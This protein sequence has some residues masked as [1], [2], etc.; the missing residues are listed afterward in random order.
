MKGDKSTSS[1]VPAHYHLLVILGALAEVIATELLLEYQ[2]HKQNLFA[3]LVVGRKN[4]FSIGLVFIVGWF[5]FIGYLLISRSKQVKKRADAH[6]SETL[7]KYESHVSKF[8]YF[9]GIVI[10]LMLLLGLI[11]VVVSSQ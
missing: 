6:N 7:K 11:S 8:M 1:L 5:I 3:R 9:V 10:F 2:E 4:M